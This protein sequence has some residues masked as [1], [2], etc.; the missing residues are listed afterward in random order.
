MTF[1]DV[2][3]FDHQMKISAFILMSKMQGNEEPS[4]PEGPPDPGQE[5]R[6]ITAY[7]SRDL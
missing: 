5:E 1:Y 3:K 2:I 6:P 4:G 7:S